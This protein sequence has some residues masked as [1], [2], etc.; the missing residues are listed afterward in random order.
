VLRSIEVA[1]SPLQLDDISVRVI[2]GAVGNASAENGRGYRP[3]PSA[4]SGSR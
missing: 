1:R 2:G 4:G 3:A